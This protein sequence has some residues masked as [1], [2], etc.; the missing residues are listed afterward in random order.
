MKTKTNEFD[1]AEFMR[2]VRQKMDVEM[3]D[4]TFAEL[5]AY[6]EQQVRRVIEPRRES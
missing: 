2:Q 3:R 4:M 6:I 1:A 5:Q